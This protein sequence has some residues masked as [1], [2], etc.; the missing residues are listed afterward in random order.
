[1]S[2]PRTGSLGISEDLWALLNSACYD[3]RNHGPWEPPAEVVESA[4]LADAAF[5]A[6][7]GRDP[8]WCEDATR[9]VPFQP[10]CKECRRGARRV[11]T[12][13]GLTDR[14]IQELFR[15]VGAKWDW[16]TDEKRA[17]RKASDHGEA[18]LDPK[19]PGWVLDSTV[20]R[21][22]Q[23]MARRIA[24]SDQKAAN[25]ARASR[26]ARHAG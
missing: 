11:L 8:E 2:I 12:R 15:L 25:K 21:R 20:R 18:I 24:Q 23:D 9:L 4:R 1:M 16:T 5:D 7:F 13:R 26:N 22:E 19:G 17:A 3:E 14:R 6:G 10:K